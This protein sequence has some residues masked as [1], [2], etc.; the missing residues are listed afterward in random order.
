MM[1]SY[2]DRRTGQYAVSRTGHSDHLST[3]SVSSTDHCARG[4]NQLTNCS[5][6]R[7]A[8]TVGAIKRLRGRMNEIDVSMHLETVAVL[9]DL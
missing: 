8:T 2:M 4:Q 3:N 7:W 1:G 6:G 5:V 9:I